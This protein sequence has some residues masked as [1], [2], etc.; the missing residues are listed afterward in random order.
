MALHQGVAAWFLR[1]GCFTPA[2]LAQRMSQRMFAAQPQPEAAHEP[3]ARDEPFE[4]E[5]RPC[6][7]FK[8][9]PPP[10]HV[11]TTVNELLYFYHQI[12]R[13]RRMEIA[14]DMVRHLKHRQC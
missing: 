3:R 1:R 12:H 10:A 7:A 11:E 6:D 8:I 4:V 5:T 13:L 9:E 2:C 14:A